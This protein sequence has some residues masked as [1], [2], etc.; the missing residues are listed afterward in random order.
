MTEPRRRAATPRDRTAG[1][2]AAI[3]VAGGLAVIAMVAQVVGGSGAGSIEPIIDEVRSAEL[4]CPAPVLT[5]DGAASRAAVAAPPASVAP[6]AGT[7]RTGL[8]VLQDLGPGGKATARIKLDSPGQAGV[9]TP[10]TPLLAR[11]TGA[12]APGLAAD[13]ISTGRTGTARGLEAVSG[14]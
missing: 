11:G 8:A 5:G 10:S 3:A 4:P 14:A 12:L 6:E 13:L 7:E 1:P 2:K 9:S